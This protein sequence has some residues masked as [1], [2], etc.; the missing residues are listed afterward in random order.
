MAKGE[1]DFGSRAKPLKE[2]AVPAVYMFQP[3]YYVVVQNDELEDWQK[4]LAERVGMKPEVAA[5]MRPAQGTYCLCGSTA[6]SEACDCDE[7]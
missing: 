2:K 1:I 7:I 4:A 3:A 6:L 5:R